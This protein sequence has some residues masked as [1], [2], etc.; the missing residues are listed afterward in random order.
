MSL[1]KALVEARRIERFRG[2]NCCYAVAWR[3]PAIYESLGDRAINQSG[4]EVPQ[5]IVSSEPLA[6]RAF[7]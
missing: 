5:A 6:E 3:Q 4:I 7:A 1:Q 2:G